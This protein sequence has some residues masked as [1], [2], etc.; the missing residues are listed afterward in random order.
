MTPLEQLAACRYLP[1][2]HCLSV[3]PVV[4]QLQAV[5]LLVLACPYYWF[6][7]GRVQ[8]VFRLLDEWPGSIVEQPAGQGVVPL[9]SG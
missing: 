4:R 2:A 5:G 3:P 6:E 7:S 8:A 1:A 9:V